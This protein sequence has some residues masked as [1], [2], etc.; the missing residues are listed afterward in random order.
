MPIRISN[1]SI[2]PN[3]PPY[4]IAEMSGNHNQY[5]KQA[6]KIV[7]AAK[8]AGAHA[9][10][11][12]TYTPDTLTI[13]VKDKD[14]LVS[15]ESNL[16]SGM[17]LYDL[18]KKA[19][20]P[21]EW[22]K[23]IFDEAKRIGIDCFSS[24]FDESSVDF[25]ENLNVPAYKIASFE[26]SHLP[27]IAKVAQTGKP[28]IISLGMATYEEVA[29]TVEIARENGCKDLIL[30]KCTSNYPAT[31]TAVNLRTIEDLRAKFGC[32]IGYSDH[33][34]G[35]GS[36]IAAVAL[37]ATVIEKHIKTSSGS[38]GVD[39]E[40]SSNE[41]EIELLVK[42]SLAAWQALGQVKYGCTEE[43]IPSLKFRRSIYFIENVEKGTIL[44]T[45]NIGIIRPGYGVQPKYIF[46]L[47]GKKI[48]FA[49]KKGQKLDPEM[50]DLIIA[51]ND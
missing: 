6:L 29:E 34:L 32:E 35:I 15:D 31:P 48:P 27:L 14:F 45:S 21:W 17:Y 37:G 40:F 44:T 12:Q 47:I 39:S 7:H 51:D 49:A 26:N 25:L 23:E 13:D 1:S 50:L 9:V 19:F 30:L 43:E 10:K 8:K 5:I 42:E 18:Y 16:W 33:T 38:P 20:T 3:F 46:K 22:H 4:V 2:G 24:A 36:S 11:L 41:V 28:V